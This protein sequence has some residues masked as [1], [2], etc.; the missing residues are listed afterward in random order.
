[1]EWTVVNM[2]NLAQQDA[3]VLFA[4]YIDIMAGMPPQCRSGGI[5]SGL[6]GW[7]HP[8]MG[9]HHATKYY[10]TIAAR[11]WQTS[12]LNPLTSSNC[13]PIAAYNDR[14][15]LWLAALMS[16]LLSLSELRAAWRACLP[17]SRGCL[18]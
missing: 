6:Q 12:G 8:V 10:C 7:P 3:G 9:K 17:I 1:M 18:L 13:G 15:S 14:S 5:I 4:Y 11:R 16:A 2:P